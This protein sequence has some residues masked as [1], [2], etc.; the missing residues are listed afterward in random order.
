[1]NA[2]VTTSITDR[3][4]IVQIDNPP[5]NALSNAV[6]SGI[7]DAIAAFGANSLVDAVLIMC[8]GRTF[9]AGADITEFGK[10]RQPPSL[11]ETCDAV[12][13]CPKPVVVALHGTALGGGFEIALAAHYRIAAP[14]AK[15]GLPEI[16]LGLIP[17]AGGANRLARIAGAEQALALAVGGDPIV[18]DAAKDAGIIDEITGGTDLAAAARDFTKRLVAEGRTTRPT[19]ARAIPAITDQAFDAAAAKWTRK[20][21]GQD[22]PFAC[23]ESVRRALTLP[24]DEAIAGDRAA[25]ATLSAGSQSRALR[26]V[27]F[28][29]RQAAK[30]ASGTARPVAAVAIIGA[31]TMG[32]GIAMSFAAVGLPV[33]LID[34]DD[35]AVQRG[36]DRIR[37]NYATSV[38]RGSISIAEADR[39]LGLIE[40]A[41]DRNAAA[42]ADLVIEAVFEN[43]ALKQEIFRDLEA[44]C[45]AE[46]VLATN[47]SA[48]DVDAIA[49]VFDKPSR[50]VGMHFFSPAN[51]M[52][53]C[54]VVRAAA[55]D[56]DTLATALA[57]AKR[58]SKV[59]VISGNC[60]GFI[61]NRMVAKRS[62]QAE[63]LLQEGAL[64]QD[65]DAA[66]RAF[67]FPMGPLQTNDMSGLD[68][69]YAIRKRRGTKFPIADAIVESGRLGQKTGAGYYRYEPGSR[70]P[71]PDP[72]TVRVIEATSA[73]LG[74][75]RRDIPQDE[76]I[77]RMI[78]ALVNE[79]AR[80]VA[81]GIASRPSD[82]DVVWVHG[83]GFPRWR[84]GPLAYA[85]ETGL[86]YIVER[87][88]AFARTSDASLAPAPLLRE[89]ADA[90]TTFAQWQKDRA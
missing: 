36:I 81:E 57:T 35:A 44:I 33:T 73:S 87:L 56:A 51:V 71:I 10:P 45:R 23:V 64:P 89:L 8:A 43:L 3:I 65:V 38:Q 26:H 60:D 69:G 7:V 46:T 30:L 12:E 29:E 70:T 67:G 2:L 62:A 18:V 27:F 80:I 58:I 24:F 37:G 49:T 40:T 55:T 39:R 53:L 17:G 9:I 79:G 13:A 32:G 6:R 14:G 78:F 34:T 74:M 59:P 75:E 15:M 61:G 83:Y 25:F 20:A 16:K 11:A 76:M 42:D 22:A 31:G 54:E 72:E 52:K 4:G 21:A 90:G 63:R 19:R 84:G 50:F 86:P 5:V 41:T 66:I 28:A 82:V 1:M 48:L 47:T 68:I 88:D 77:E 85:D